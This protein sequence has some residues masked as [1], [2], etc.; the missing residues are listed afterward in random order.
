MATPPS[1]AIASTM[2]TPGSVGRPG[3]WPAKNG[4]SPVR[5]H[6]PR[7]LTPGSTSSMVSIRRKGGRCGRTSSGRMELTALLPVEGAQEVRRGVLGRDLV[8]G[9]GD[10]GLGVYQEGRA[11]DPHVLPAVHAALPPY[12]VG[13]GHCVVLVGEQ[14]EPEAVLLEPGLPG[15]LV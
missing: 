15:R 3:K 14:G 5:C 9:L 4:S 12:S 6:D 1:C 11:D 8:P 13:L 10:L 2:S 7:A